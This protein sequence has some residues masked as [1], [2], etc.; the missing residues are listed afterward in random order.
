MHTA[1]QTGS[2]RAFVG[3]HPG[4][5]VHLHLLQLAVGADP[6]ARHTRPPK[7][8][9]AGIDAHGI[10]PALHPHAKHA[11]DGAPRPAY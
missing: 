4:G 2:R 7:Q 10:P 1:V 6:R 5:I 8:P 11:L 3:V 9:L